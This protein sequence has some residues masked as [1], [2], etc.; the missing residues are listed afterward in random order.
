MAFG[1]GRL[2]IGIFDHTGAS[3]GG[4]TL[5]AARLA[6]LLSKNYAVDFIR[7]WSGFSP[8]QL[9]SIFSLN[10]D[11]VNAAG[12]DAMWESFD[13]PGRYSLVQQLRRS[14][15]LT[16][17][18]DLFIY[19]GHWVPPFC[20]ARHG[21]I[22]CHFPIGLP[23]ASELENNERWAHRTRLGRWLRTQVY[24]RAWQERFKGY[25]AILANS[26]FTAGW[27]QRRWGV[28][29]EVVY[30]PVDLEVQ[31]SPK[32]NRIVTIG[33]F[34][35]K[36]P[37]CKGHLAQ[38]QSFRE[39]L[40]KVHEPW[41]LWMIG[42]ALSTEDRAYLSTVQE[43]AGSLPV[44]FF[45][46]VERRA[47]L[48]ALAGAKVFWHTAGLFENKSANPIFAEHF[49]M[50]TVESMRAGCVPIVINSGG[51]REIVESGINGFLC[52]NIP[53]LVEN[54]LAIAESAA[55]RSS[56]AREAKR[57]SFDFSAEAFDNHVLAIVSQTLCKQPKC[58]HTSR[59]AEA[60]IRRL[61]P[62]P[63]G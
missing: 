23:S 45:V 46:N 42:S 26:D 15:K 12:C 27:I 48:E 49:G 16:A 18:Y 43:A 38:I 7:D 28:P 11:G 58:G 44:R 6:T 59:K 54:T 9:S 20:Q 52:E 47:V 24:R 30:P 39:F 33:R 50:A 5:V 36:E 8:G 32:Q 22:Y 19:A 41:E 37:R 29:A 51:Q 31:E 55:L 63:P 40:T 1:S 56:M 10:L 3:V 53:A 13:V 25:D 14:E 34:F 35:G 4:G 2:R 61:R 21:L 17:G 62:W 57:R 60:P